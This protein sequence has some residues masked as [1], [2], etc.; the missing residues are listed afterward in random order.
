MTP[1][2]LAVQVCNFQVS[3][4]KPKKEGTNGLVGSNEWAENRGCEKFKRDEIKNR[5]ELKTD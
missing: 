1:V 3:S 5:T 4:C 2:D